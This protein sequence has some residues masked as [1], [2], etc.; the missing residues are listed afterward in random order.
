ME[1]LGAGGAGG[2]GGGGGG[3]GRGG[4]HAFGGGYGGAP[5]SAPPKS[6]MVT[7][8]TGP[9]PMGRAAAA[10]M[11]AGQDGYRQAPPAQLRCVRVPCPHC[12]RVYSC[13]S[14]VF[15]CVC[16]CICVGGCRLGAGAVAHASSRRVS[17]SDVV[18]GGGVCVWGG[19]DS[20]LDAAGRLRYWVWTCPAGGGKQQFTEVF[21]GLRGVRECEGGRAQHQHTIIPALRTHALPVPGRAFPGISS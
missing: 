12:E 10:Q 15:L 7:Y 1:P 13:W 2:Y 9:M 17:E 8:D 18:W 21:V 6:S 16:V 19:G 20:W 3:G 5:G 4:A 14:V 11:A